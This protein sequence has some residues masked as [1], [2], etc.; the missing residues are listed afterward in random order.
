MSDARIGKKLKET[1]SPSKQLELS[2]NENDSDWEIV[3]KDEEDFFVEI[4][5]PDHV[6]EDLEKKLQQSNKQN[7]TLT[8]KLTKTEL[9]LKTTK[10]ELKESKKNE[11]ATYTTHGKY[12]TKNQSHHQTKQSRSDNPSWRNK[13]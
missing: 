2:D 4:T 11:K 3:L 10:I 9:Q 13:R 8:K 1:I 5:N 7:K 12:G 6:I